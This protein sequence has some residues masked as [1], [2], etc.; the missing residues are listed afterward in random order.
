MFS[1]SPP[2]PGLGGCPF[3]SSGPL[4]WKRGKIYVGPRGKKGK[5]L[6]KCKKTQ[7]ASWGGLLWYNSVRNGVPPFGRYPLSAPNGEG[8]MSL[9]NKGTLRMIL[10]IVSL[11]FVPFPPFIIIYYLAPFTFFVPPYQQMKVIKQNF[12]GVKFKKKHWQWKQ[13]R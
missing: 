1:V 4:T 8:Y 7:L 12:Q 13:K 10:G 6:W 2:S 11:K 5:K 9:Q 3:Y